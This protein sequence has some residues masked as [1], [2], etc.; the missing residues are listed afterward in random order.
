VKKA[1]ARQ[2]S[3]T[4]APSGYKDLNNT[5]LVCRRAKLFFIMSIGMFQACRKVLVIEII[6][7]EECFK[8]GRNFWT[9]KIVTD[10]F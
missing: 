10:R 8:G 5:K 4:L 2:V 9:G 1:R 3:Y 6:M 7:K